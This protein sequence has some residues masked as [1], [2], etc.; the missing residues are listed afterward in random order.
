ML[1]REQRAVQ[2]WG[3]VGTQALEIP[4]PSKNASLMFRINIF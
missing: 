4:N 1:Q 2:V 3:G